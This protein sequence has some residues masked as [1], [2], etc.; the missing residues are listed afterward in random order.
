[1]THQVTDATR[2]IVE[3]ASGLGLAHDVISTLIGVT[4][5]T[6]R[7]RYRKELDQGMAKTHFNIAKTT[8]EKAMGGNSTM[9][10]WFE[11]TRM[12]M[13]ETVQVATPPG[14]AFVSAAG[15]PELIGAYYARLRAAGLA[16][17]GRPLGAHSGAD[18]PVGEGGQGAQG[19]EGDPEAGEG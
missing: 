5:K 7:K 2:K 14:E 8:Y 16:E 18:P 4:G 6:L 11:K 10:I 17:D 12:G 1:M 19:R 15:E 3:N 9:L 13:R